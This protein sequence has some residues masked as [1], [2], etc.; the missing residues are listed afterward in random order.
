[1]GN[2][3]VKMMAQAIHD[4]E[5]AEAKLDLAFKSMTTEQ[6]AN[7]DVSVAIRFARSAISQLKNLLE[8]ISL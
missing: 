7:D 5:I 2:V 4:A 1:M 8:D 3:T 6:E